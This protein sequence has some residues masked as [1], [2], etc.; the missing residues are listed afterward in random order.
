MRTLVQS[1]KA[2]GRAVRDARR[3]Q[4]LTQRNVAEKAGIGQPTVSNVERGTQSVTLD[5]L[6]RILSTLR[7]ELIIQDRAPL[8]LQ[9]PRPDGS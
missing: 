6:L 9:D 1:Q 7:L 4:G 3:R 2:L 5:T 8:P